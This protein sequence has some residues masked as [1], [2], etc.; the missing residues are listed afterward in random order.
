MSARPHEE[1]L[2]I[3]RLA[4][5]GD[6][7]GRLSDGRAAFVPFTAPGD[8]VRVRIVREHR[9]YVRATVRA[10]LRAG[11]GRTEP[12]CA[13][14]GS[15]GGCRW[16][17]LDTATQL[18]ARRR[19]IEDALT[20][21]AKLVPPAP[22][23]IIPSPEPYAYRGRTRVLVEGGRVGFRRA[24]SHALCATR[25][26]PV[27]VPALDRA[28]AELAASPPPADGEWELVSDSHGAVRR[29]ACATSRPGDSTGRDADRR[30]GNEDSRTS[31]RVAL[32][33]DGDDA[34][35]I[36]PRVFAQ[37]NA[38][39]VERLVEAVLD[40][41]GEGD[42]AIE[43]F[44]GAGL[45]T[46]GLARRFRR[47]VAVEA[48]PDAAR[49]L[50]A[51]LREAGLDGVTPLAAR[52]EQFLEEQRALPANAAARWQ[53]DLFVLDPPRRGL[54]PGAAE[55]LAALGAARIVYSSC[56]PATWAR[57]LG[58]LADRGYRLCSVTGFDLFPQTPHVET[59]AVLER[60]T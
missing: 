45:F 38:L 37:S 8:R 36:S 35:R 12:R 31:S 27:L 39:L 55:S 16:Q 10:L 33:D 42:L 13:V 48:D 5:D 11:P 3:D 44:A 2:T 28:L 30:E 40:A 32:H 50:A 4:S 54:A 14:F 18:E 56:D 49:D 60:E 1:E 43:L 17:H 19:R 29:S 26:C 46:R 25:H 22:V 24:R 34:L 20:R 7:V 47:V 23:R 51:N 57:D 59:L 41:A 58:V 53:P 52:A 6:G 15:C 21:I 9:R